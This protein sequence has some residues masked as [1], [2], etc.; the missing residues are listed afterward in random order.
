MFN[1]KNHTRK[2]SV[3]GSLGPVQRSIGYLQGGYKDSTIHS[4][5]Q[6]FNINTQVGS[7]VYDTGY[8]RSYRPGL[9]G[10][11]SGYFSIN[12]TTAFNK[13][14]YISASAAASFT[15]T[16]VYPS[17][18]AS[19]FNV[20]TLGWILGT[21]AA[22]W[23]GAA[24]TGWYRLNF[25]TESP[26]SYGALST[27]PLG[28]TRQALSSGVAA[29]FMDTTGTTFTALNF[30]T[31]AVVSSQFSTSISSLQ[32]AVG[33]SQSN[34]QGYFVAATPM[35]VRLTL[36]TSTI[37]AAAAGTAYT[38]N[39]AESHSLSSSASAYLMAGYSDTTGRYG[40]TQ[41]GLC[42][43]MTFGTEAMTALADLVLPQ[44]SGQ[45]MQ[46]F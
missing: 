27:A 30:T 39:F 42:Q 7:L 26:V 29:F 13:F 12:D 37:T 46:G 38:Y 3:P 28:I 45:M 21:A 40:G 16:G 14:D 32:I 23:A 41:H 11:H 8:Q 19:D 20:Y 4:K 24:V 43:K 18:T 36:S 34:T 5:V 44:S 35:N 10:N 15:M 31:N 2:R 22:G 33:V 17:V 9:S 1:L 6:L 25:L